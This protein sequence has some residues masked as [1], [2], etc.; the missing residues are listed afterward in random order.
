LYNV[1]AVKAV[2]STDKA[3]VAAAALIHVDAA[4]VL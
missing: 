3:V 2:R 4:F 1:P